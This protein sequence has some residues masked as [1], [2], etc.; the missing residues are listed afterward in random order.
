MTTIKELITHLEYLAPRGMQ[1]SYDN[2]G[3]LIGNKNTTISGVLVCLDCVESV[4]DEAIAKGCNLIVAHHPLIFKGLKRITGSGYVERTVEKCIK[5]DIA[6]YA[7]HTNFDNYHQGVNAEFGRRLG[8]T[9]VKILSP[10][11][12]V[13]Y[14]LVV[15]CPENEETRL[16]D[17]LFNA[18]AG[19]IG[20]YSNCNFS[21]DGMGSFQ[22][23][24]GANPKVGEIGSRTIL[25]EKRI[26]YMVSEHRL[27][28]SLVAM[29]AALS[30]E[31]IAHDIIKLSNVNQQEGS[32]MLGELAEPMRAIDFLKQV[33]QV[34]SCGA[35]RFTAIED[36]LVEK[37]A[38]CGGSGSFLLNHA[39]AEG[40]DVFVTADFKY[41]EFFDADGQ[42]IVADIGH[43]ESEQFTSN[44]LVDILTKKFTTFAVRLTE[45]N[46]NPIN[47]L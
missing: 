38:F 25:S 4:V 26:E 37:I 29:R 47:Y 46:T 32:G 30:Y 20:N 28:A 22:P 42:I 3:L 14:K 9:N 40:A 31:E 10:K 6:V 23:E 24:A 27:S 7:I 11:S 21:S 36:Q 15:F 16:N 44:L 2:S 34:F 5:N 13:L 19:H 18:G 8:L 17:A 33:K 35:I 1:E 12:E 45:L 43:Y 39:I 41:H